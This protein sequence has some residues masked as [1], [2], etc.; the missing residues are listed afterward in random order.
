M[1]QR[2]AKAA[3]SARPQLRAFVD[4]NGDGP[5][6]LAIMD[7]HVLGHADPEH[8]AA[9]FEGTLTVDVSIESGSIVSAYRKE[10]RRRFTS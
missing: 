4:Q 2:I 9:L 10:D 6:I 7:S 3:H 5:A 1:G 8:L